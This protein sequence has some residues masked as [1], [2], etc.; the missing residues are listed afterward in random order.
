MTRAKT[1]NTSHLDMQEILDK[2]ANTQGKMFDGFTYC[3]VS[4]IL[5]F[6][7]SDYLSKIV[8]LEA[9]DDKD[10]GVKILY[11]REYA[12]RT[13]NACSSFTPELLELTCKILDL[14]PILLI[15]E[16]E[17]YTA[18][19][20]LLRCYLDTINKTPIEFLLMQQCINNSEIKSLTLSI[21]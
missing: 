1:P 13:I 8:T 6:C 7:I 21:V 14:S 10:K 15:T 18:R 20:V 4:E 16:I 17:E 2:L 9:G 5:R 3:H 12:I 11:F 19:V